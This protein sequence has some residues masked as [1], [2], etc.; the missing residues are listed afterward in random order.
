MVYLILQI[1]IALIIAF[2][3]WFELYLILRL[4]LGFIS[5]GIVFSGFV[6][7]KYYYNYINDLEIAVYY[8]FLLLCFQGME[9]VGG[10]WR[11]ISGVSYLFPVPVAY[12]SIAGIAYLVRGWVNLQLAITLPSLLLLGFWW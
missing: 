7:C 6:L 2:S 5:V 8:L 10:K 3:P 4:F 9:L 1:M 12:I 11:T